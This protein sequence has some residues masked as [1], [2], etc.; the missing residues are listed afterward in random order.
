M[1]HWERG[2]E[3]RT[4]VL[5]ALCLVLQPGRWERKREEKHA[6]SSQYDFP[7]LRSL[8]AEI[9]TAVGLRKEEID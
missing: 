5:Q 3:G 7:L 1:S 4:G 8:D 2:S 6:R 9:H